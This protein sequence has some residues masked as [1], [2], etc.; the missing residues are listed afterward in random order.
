MSRIVDHVEGAQRAAGVLAARAN[1][2][3]EGAS[4]LLGQFSSEG[5][6]AASFMT[7][8]ELAV[9]LHAA[10]TGEHPAE[11]LQ[12]LAMHLAGAAAATHE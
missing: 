1:D 6:I 10:D 4:A 2:D 5:Q 3:P 8:A 12:E 9:H 7:V 11:F